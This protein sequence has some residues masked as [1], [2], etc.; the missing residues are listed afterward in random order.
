M[1]CNNTGNVFLREL[2]KFA[3]MHIFLN[4][5]L[6]L[7]KNQGN[8]MMINKKYVRFSP[9]ANYMGKIQHP[10]FYEVQILFTAQV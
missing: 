7:A 1:L 6:L 4:V 3:Q 10:W 9:Y 8:K 5:I 2:C